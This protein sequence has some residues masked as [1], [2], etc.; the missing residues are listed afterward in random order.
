MSVREFSLINEKGDRYS[1]MDIKNKCLLTNP[2]GLGYKYNSTYEQIGDYFIQNLRQIEQGQITG[3]INCLSYDNFTDLVNFIET[4]EK[5]RFAY[6]IPYDNRETVEFYKDVSIQS[7]SK[8]EK[9]TNGVITEPIVFDCLSL[10]YEENVQIFTIEPQS[11]EVKW[12]F[13]WPAKFVN[14]KDKNKEFKNNGHTEAPV[15]IEISGHVINPCI[16]VYI[17]NDLV[18]ELKINIEIEEYEKFLYG[19]IPNQFY[20]ERERTNGTKESLKSLDYLDFYNDNVIRLAK[21]ETSRIKLS[22]DNNI[23]NAKIKVMPQYKIL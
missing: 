6:K 10:W 2:G 12:P 8:T 17:E 23:I 16:Q 18:Q 9:Q 5:L 4:A 19:T 21:G 13:K 11:N 15:E 1:L 20:I 22:A 3:D 7:I 14:L